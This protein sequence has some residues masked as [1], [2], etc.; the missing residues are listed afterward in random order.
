MLP[1][2]LRKRD[3]RPARRVLAILDNPLHVVLRCADAI[4]PKARYVL[5]TLFMACGIPVV[6]ANEP[7]PSG[8]WLAYATTPESGP[9]ADR[10]LA[11]AHAPDAWRLFGGG[12]DVEAAASLDGLPAVLPRL[13]EGFDA[14]AAARF[15]VVANAFYFLSS[16]SERRGNVAT[17]SRRLYEDSVFARLSVR[18]RTTE[19]TWR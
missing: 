11:I 1:P 15:D 13:V 5:D 18:K 19:N 14:R 2:C 3:L 9:A 7:P 16:W 17:R 10:C 12:A 8:A 4:V 6:Y